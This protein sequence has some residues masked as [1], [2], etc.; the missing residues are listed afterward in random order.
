MK[1]NKDKKEIFV[2]KYN[3][4]IENIEKENGEKLFVVLCATPTDNEL[5][6]VKPRE[7]VNL[8][9]K[10]LKIKRLGVNE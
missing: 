8:G 7:R 9:E 6:R 4:T 1:K 2:E 3:S 5:M 10:K